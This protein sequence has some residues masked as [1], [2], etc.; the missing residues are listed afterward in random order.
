MASNIARPLCLGMCR[1]R[2][3]THGL[4]VPNVSAMRQRARWIVLQL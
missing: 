1:S 2:T 3:I 4:G